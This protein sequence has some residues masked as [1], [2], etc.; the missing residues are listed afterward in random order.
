MKY[1]ITNDLKLYAWTL[2]ANEETDIPGL[3]QEQ[4]PNGQ[5]WN[6]RE[7]VENFVFDITGSKYETPIEE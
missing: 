7:E 4:N 5:P 6:S 1:L 2:D 3:A